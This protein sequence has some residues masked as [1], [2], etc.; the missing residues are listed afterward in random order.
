MNAS[1]EGNDTN[2]VN[3]VFTDPCAQDD[4]RIGIQGACEEVGNG[5]NLSNGHAQPAF[6][7]NKST[8]GP[9]NVHGR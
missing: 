4:L 7:L 2:G 3:Q 1:Q 5:V 9:T 8:F 6:D